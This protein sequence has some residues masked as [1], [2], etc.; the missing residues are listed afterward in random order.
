M[1]RYEHPPVVEVR[2]GDEEALAHAA[3]EHIEGFR[4]ALVGPHAVDLLAKRGELVGVVAKPESSGE[5][6][7]PIKVIDLSDD[8]FGTEIF[9]QNDNPYAASHRMQLPPDIGQLYERREEA[10]SKKRRSEAPRE[11][12][13]DEYFENFTIKK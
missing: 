8:D 5:K 2:A 6:K 10:E 13:D 1:R 4:K 3:P 11:I 7:Q 9:V 12:S